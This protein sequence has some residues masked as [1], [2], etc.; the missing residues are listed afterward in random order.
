MAV[1]IWPLLLYY[2]R[3]QVE[4]DQSGK[5]EQTNKVTVL[6]F[7]N[8]VERS[9]LISASQKRKVLAVLKKRRPQWSTRLTIVYVFSVLV[10]LLVKDHMEKLSLIIIDK[11]YPGHE[12]V[13]KNRIL[14][15]CRRRGIVIH[16]DQIVFANIGKKSPAHKLAW[17][18]Y[19]RLVDPDQVLS[20]HDVLTEFGE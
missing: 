14:T 6:A 17:K 13:I 2:E 19:N 8:G 9:I 7:A 10:Y 3:M 18:A 4:V 12:A 11:E 5:V 16:K 15:L 1:L 20:A